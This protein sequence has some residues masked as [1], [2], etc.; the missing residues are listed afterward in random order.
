MT[1]ESDSETALLPVPIRT[2]EPS[3]PTQKAV[4]VRRRSV[5]RLIRLL[6]AA[7]AVVC[8]VGAAVILFTSA[9][10]D[11]HTLPLYM[12]GDLT[13]GRQFVRYVPFAPPVGAPYA[14]KSKPNDIKNPPVPESADE[15]APLS[16]EERTQLLY[17][18]NETPYEPDM[19]ALL[20]EDRVI[21]TMAELTDACG[22][23]APLV[24]ILH[25]HG[26]EAYADTADDG[27]RSTDP[28]VNV[29]SVGAA[30]ADRLTEAGIPVIHDTVCYDYPD[31]TLAYYDASRSIRRT[32][33]A[34][35][36]ICYVLDV[37]R[38]SAETEDGVCYAPAVL[39][40][41]G[42]AA[43]LMFV[44]GTDYG[45]SGHTAWADNLA[46]AARLQLRLGEDVPGLMRPINVRSA[47]FNEQYTHGSLL[48]EVGTCGNTR[49]E[50]LAAIFY[51][52]DA[53]IDEIRG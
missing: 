9:G 40:E 41:K 45:G 21:P 14:D 29:V 6:L 38:D 3:T 11:R 50:A 23:D 31:Y 13:G 42:D 12:L 47:S 32:L 48:L 53:F 37:H 33:E 5:F 43:Q 17:L 39:S 16:A 2:D 25:T 18:S 19:E 36:S 24:L 22:E 52:A 8:F 26:T 7:V 20:A 27:Y 1:H 30:L 10:F 51:F 4:P 49:E 46:L 28:A 15:H 34:Y 35:P 44:V